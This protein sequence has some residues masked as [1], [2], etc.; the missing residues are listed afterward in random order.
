MPF[1]RRLAPMEGVA[2]FAIDV[3]MFAI[4]WAIRSTTTAVTSVLLGGTPMLATLRCPVRLVDALQLI[5]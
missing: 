2:R 5:S 4:N 1:A 3:S